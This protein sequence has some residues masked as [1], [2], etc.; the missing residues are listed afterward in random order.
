MEELECFNNEGNKGIKRLKDN[1]EPS[2]NRMAAE[3]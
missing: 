1:K 3:M 2:V